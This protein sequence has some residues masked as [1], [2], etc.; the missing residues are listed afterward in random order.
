MP[1]PVFIPFR[2][3]ETRVRHDDPTLKPYVPMAAVLR[4]AASPR[5]GR[6]G[7]P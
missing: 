7:A 3:R 6:P 1:D 4:S 5:H 2:G